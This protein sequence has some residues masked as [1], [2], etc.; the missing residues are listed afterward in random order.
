MRILCHGG[1][2]TQELDSVLIVD[3]ALCVLNDFQP[4]GE[5][6]CL[7][8]VKAFKSVGRISSEAKLLL[9]IGFDHQGASHGQPPN[10][11]FHDREAWVKIRD[12][13]RIKRHEG[14]EVKIQA[15]FFGL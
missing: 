7:V 10:Q 8:A 2:D 3:E 5:F 11:V 15:G 9:G 14:D 6:E 12:Q 13:N 4:F 1:F